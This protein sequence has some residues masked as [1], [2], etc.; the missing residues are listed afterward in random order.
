[1]ATSQ[2][3]LIGDENIS[4]MASKDIVQ[5]KVKKPRQPKKK[6]VVEGDEETK[7]DN[8]DQLVVS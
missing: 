4:S 2:T 8:C 5:P 7:R 6:A 1:M 3:N